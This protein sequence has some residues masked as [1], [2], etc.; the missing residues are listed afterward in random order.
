MAVL[1]TPVVA[2]LVSIFLSNAGQYH[3]GWEPI[4]FYLLGFATAMTSWLWLMLGESEDEPPPTNGQPPAR[5]Q[6]GH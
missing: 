6:D 5:A 2:L 4:W 3:W 1:T